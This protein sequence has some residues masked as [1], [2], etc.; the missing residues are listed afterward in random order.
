MRRRCGNPFDRLPADAPPR[1]I[2]PPLTLTTLGGAVTRNGC[3]AL[4]LDVTEQGDV[5]RVVAHEAVDVHPDVVDSIT[6]A[7]AAGATSRRAATASRC[8]RA[9][10]SW[11]S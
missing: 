6:M 4:V 8:R 10:A 5:A 7:A 3:L 11:C 1:R 9:C 2:G